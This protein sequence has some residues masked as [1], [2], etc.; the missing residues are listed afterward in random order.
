MSDGAIIL[1]LSDF[2]DRT[3]PYKTKPCDKQGNPMPERLWEL[4]QLCFKRQASERPVVAAI[5]AMLPHLQMKYSSLS[6]AES[7]PESSPTTDSCEHPTSVSNSAVIYG[8]G[9]QRSHL[10]GEDATVR[11]GPL[12]L[13]ENAE[14]PLLYDILDRLLKAIRRDVLV[15]PHTVEKHSTQYFDLRFQSP[16]EANNF[17]MTWMF[18]RYDPYKEVS[19]VLLDVE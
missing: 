7:S 19:A 15:L 8:K 3:S 5:A 14:G 16:M 17:A 2:R 1:A 10:Q 6:G 9:K 12:N 4:A 13:D 11:F 18:Y